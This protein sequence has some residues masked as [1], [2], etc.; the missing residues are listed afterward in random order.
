MNYRIKNVISRH[1]K[2]VALF[3]WILVW[4]LAAVGVGNPLILPSVGD[5]LMALGPILTDPAS[6]LNLLLTLLRVFGG[7]GISVVAGLALGIASGLNRVVRG[8]VNPVTALIRTLPVV[9]VILLINLWVRSGV[10]PLVVSF[11]VC[12]PI[13]WTNAVEGIE[14]TDSQLLEMA[15]VYGVPAP[16]VLQKIYLPSVRPY[17]LAALTNAVGMGWKATVTA[18]VLANALPSVG[19]NLYYAKLYLETPT[20]FAWTF[21]LVLASFI[22]EK[23]TGFVIQ[24]RQK[25]D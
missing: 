16:R 19:M 18:E 6:A 15:K 13:V 3:F 14:N 20:L 12:F 22:I 11:M 24:K 4:Q 17:F 23:I 1:I 10:V 5:T 21:I 25:N 9:S 8:I 2:M 7:V